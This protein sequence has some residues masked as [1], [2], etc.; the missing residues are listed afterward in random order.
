VRGGGAK[1]SRYQFQTQRASIFHNR[2]AQIT[3]HF[4]AAATTE[5]KTLKEYLASTSYILILYKT[6]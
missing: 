1:Q 5:A 3:T 2:I 6:K 4:E